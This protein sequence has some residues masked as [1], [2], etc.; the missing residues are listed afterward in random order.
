MPDRQKALDYHALGRPGKIEVVATKPLETQR[1]LAR[2]YTP[3]VA[4]ACREISNDPDAV[5]K[6]TARG[7]LVAVVTNGTAVLGLGDLGPAAAKPVMEGKANLFK[8]FADVDVFDIEL[9]ARTVDEIVTAVKAIAPTFGGINLEDIKAPECFEVERRLVEE[10]DIPV[11]HDDQHGTAIISAAALLNA[12]A[13]SKRKL[14]D[15]KMVIS[16]AGAAA[17][18]CA[19]L[20]VAL[21]MKREH[22]VLFDSKGAITKSR[23]DLVPTKAAYAVDREYASFREALQGADAFVGLS[24]ADLITGE[25]ILGMNKQPIIFAM[26]NPDP[27]IGY[28]EAK[29]VRPD[30][31]VATGRSDFPNQVNNVLGFPFVFRGALDCRASKIT[32]EMKVAATE[33]LAA[34]TRESVPENVLRVYGLTDL[35]FG[36]DYIIPKPFDARVLTWVAPA[37]AKAAAASGVARHPIADYESYRKSLYHLVER[38]RGKEWIVDLDVVVVVG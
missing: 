12:A 38:T 32:Q 15:V 1:D 23:K 18:A 29:R 16:G 28:D 31:I 37:V 6:Y 21:G 3:G 19:D 22:I 20:Y 10:L 7:N 25:D 34:L 36:P 8:K 4:E 35:K 2:A 14:A 24:I 33:A 17:I 9:D 5:F 11:F 26:A 30:A 13:L 27:E